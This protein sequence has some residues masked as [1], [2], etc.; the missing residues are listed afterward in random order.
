MTTDEMRVEAERL[1][2]MAD[3]V[4]SFNLQAVTRDDHIGAAE[5][6]LAFYEASMKLQL[7]LAIVEGLDIESEGSL[8]FFRVAAELHVGIAGLLS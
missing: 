2:A 3:E 1:N 5:G 6:L 8:R 7:N 4:L